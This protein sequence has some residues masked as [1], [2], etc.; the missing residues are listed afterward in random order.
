MEMWVDV[1]TAITVPV[2]LISLIDDTDF[3][4]RE[5]GIVYNQAGMDLVWNFQTTAGVSSQTQVIPTTAGNHDWINTGDGM[6]G[7]E[8]PMSGGDINNDTEGAGWF[9]GIC[10]GV[11]AWRSPIMG[12][13]SA[14]LNDLLINGVNIPAIEANIELH[15]SNAINNTIPLYVRAEG[16]ITADNTEQ[17]IYEANPTVIIT[18]DSITL[19]LG[20][21]VAND[22][23]VIRMYTKLESGGDYKLIDTQAYSDAKT[24]P[25]INITGWPNRHG[26][27][28]TIEQTAG[29]L[30]DFD[31][32]SY[33]LTT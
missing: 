23:I 18:P 28:T 21:M 17:T 29:V 32:E 11:L 31:W 19:D 22:R 5:T 13:R 2:N 12:F 8:I 30:K 16:T 9:T 7:I 27:K 14:A 20:N 6:Y 1:D 24:I 10:D 15:V 25:T 33:T 4:T 26:W 3:K